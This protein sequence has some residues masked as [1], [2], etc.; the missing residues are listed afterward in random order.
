MSNRVEEILHD[1][2]TLADAALAAEVS[3][4]TIWRWLKAGRLQ[5][6]RVGREVL[7][8]KASVEALRR[9][10]EPLIVQTED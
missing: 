4:V 10:R 1:Y 6:H 9:S 2:Y 8:E 7:I 3:P 5:D